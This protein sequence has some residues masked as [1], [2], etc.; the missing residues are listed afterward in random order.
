[1]TAGARAAILILTAT[2]RRRDSLRVALAPAVGDFPLA[3]EMLIA[4]AGAATVKD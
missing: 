4:L 2:P 3:V 1:M